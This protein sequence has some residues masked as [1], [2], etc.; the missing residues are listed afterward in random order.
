MKESKLLT[1]PYSLDNSI[2]DRHIC[3]ILSGLYIIGSKYLLYLVNR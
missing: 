1:N 2:Y 3:I